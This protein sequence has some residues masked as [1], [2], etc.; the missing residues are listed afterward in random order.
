MLAGMA[1]E[2]LTAA[3]TI[4]LGSWPD[5]IAAI[6]TSLAFVVATVSY[7][8]SVEVRREAQARLVYSKI[9]HVQEHEPLAEFEMLPNGARTGAGGEGVGIVTAALTGGEPR[10]LAVAAIIQLTAV[11]HNGSKELIGPVKLQV[12]DKGLEAT[13]DTVSAVFGPIEPESDYVVSFTVRNVHH[14][15]SPSL[16]TTLLFRDASGQWWRRHL[17][18]PIE[19]VHDDPENYRYTTAEHAEFA[20]NARALGIE[21]EPEGKLSWRV[22]WHRFVRARRGKSPI[23]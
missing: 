8:R 21:P 2:L 11:I 4:T 12:V 6:F 20:A 22:R 10:Y 5:W 1:E 14:P 13:H 16:G 18:E 19:R 7:A 23:P 17:A 3:A 9:T 15:G